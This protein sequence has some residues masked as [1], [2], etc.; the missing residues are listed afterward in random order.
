MKQFTLD[1]AK[2]T[3]RPVVILENWN[4]VNALLDTGAYFP[5][6]VDDE[7]LLQA[8]GGECKG[9]GVSFGGFGGETK[10]NLYVLPSLVLGNLIF[11]NMHII[12]CNDLKNTPF[13]LILSA[14]MFK[15]LIYEIDDKNHKLNI[16]VPD[17]ESFVRNLTIM[18]NDG[19]LHVYC[20]S[21]NENI[22][23]KSQVSVS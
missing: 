22:R 4:N 21:G 5:V 16:S 14:T 15:G 11:P 10:G 3:Q 7:S 13:Q 19:K 20:S 6:W 17:K 1:L 18:D 23:S 9:K 8:L 2:N 12:A